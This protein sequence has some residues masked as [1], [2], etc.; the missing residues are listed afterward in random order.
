MSEKGKAILAYVFGFVGGLVVLFG[1]QD[2]QRNTK[3]HAAQSIVLSIAQILGNI[4]IAILPFYIP[5]A[6][7]ALSIVIFILVLMG[8]MKAYREEDP[9]LQVV[10]DIAMNIFGNAINAEPVVRP[11]YPQQ[12]TQAPAQP[13]MGQQPVQAAAQPPVGQQPVGQQ[14]AQEPVQAPVQQPTNRFCGSCGTQL[15]ANDKFCP[16]CGSAVEVRV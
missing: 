14:P 9:Q 11:Q 6:S 4:I 16:N 1:L 12:P 10:G 8:I 15:T 5:F 2:S 13:P 3:M 7:S